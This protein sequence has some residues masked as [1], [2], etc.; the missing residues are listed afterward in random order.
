MDL[1]TQWFQDFRIV[2]QQNFKPVQILSLQ[3]LRFSPPNFVPLPDKYDDVFHLYNDQLCQF[4][5]TSSPNTLFCLICGQLYFKPKHIP[6]C[7][8]QKQRYNQVEILLFKFV[9]LL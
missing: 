6:C 3:S 4:C 9:S 2:A 7:E 8:Q 1:L 5:R